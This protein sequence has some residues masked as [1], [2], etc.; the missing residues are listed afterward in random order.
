M[1]KTKTVIQKS[2]DVG[3]IIDAEYKDTCKLLEEYGDVIELSS[4][5]SLFSR[6]GIITSIFQFSTKEIFKGGGDSIVGFK[7]K[8]FDSNHFVKRTFDEMVEYFKIERNMT[9]YTTSY[10]P[11]EAILYFQ[12]REYG[13][14]LKLSKEEL[15]LINVPSIFGIQDDVSKKVRSIEQKDKFKTLST[16]HIFN[17]IKP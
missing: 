15:Q 5:I 8:G 4:T 16:K 1:K 14:L 17:S 6:K 9:V 11:E 10:A 7:H 2:N 3:I 13:R 12:G